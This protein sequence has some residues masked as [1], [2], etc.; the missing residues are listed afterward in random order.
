MTKTID[1]SMSHPPTPP[2]RDR[3]RRRLRWT[4]GS[5]LALSALI[6]VA[7]VLLAPRLVRA[8]GLER[9]IWTD[10]SGL[11]ASPEFRYLLF[12]TNAAI[13]YDDAT[14]TNNPSKWERVLLNR[15]PEQGA[16]AIS[17][18][19]TRT[20]VLR[21]VD[22]ATM[23]LLPEDPAGVQSAL[24]AFVE[25]VGRNRDP[26][27]EWLR[28]DVSEQAGGAQVKLEVADTR[29]SNIYEYSVADGRVI[30]RRWTRRSRDW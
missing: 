5:L 25:L 26:K 2:Q 1:S 3:G 30:P 22:G 14:L 11:P 10:Q 13:A 24:E 4:V 29:S 23:A 12:P 19:D 21:Y 18:R 16:R 17:A 27:I 8:L 20:G 9:E 28:F 7:A 15:L 6:A